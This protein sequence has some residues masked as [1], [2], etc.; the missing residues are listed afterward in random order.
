MKLLEQMIYEKGEILNGNILKVDSFM[1]HQIDPELM[2]KMGEEFAKHFKEK[3]ITKVLTVESSGI[4]PALMTAL[5]LQVPVVFLKKAKPSTMQDPVC[6]DVFSYTK[7]KKTTLCMEKKYLNETDRVLF[8]DDFLAN[9][10]AFKGAENIVNEC[11]AKMVGVGIVIEKAFQKGHEYIVGKDYDLY[12]L[13][14][15]QSFENGKIEFKKG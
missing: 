11:H 12:S 5:K 13:A 7:N 15:I 14:E 9:G 10:E 8:I 2:E 4:A 6:C 1:N 3:G